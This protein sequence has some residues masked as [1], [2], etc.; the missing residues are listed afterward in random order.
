MGWTPS[1]LSTCYPRASR[2]LIASFVRDIRKFSIVLVLSLYVTFGH[3]N[4]VK[5]TTNLFAQALAHLRL[6]G[7]LTLITMT[8]GRLGELFMLLRYPEQLQGTSREFNAQLETASYRKMKD[9]RVLLIQYL[10]QQNSSITGED[11]IRKGASECK[12]Y[13]GMP[14]LTDLAVM[15][16]I[17]PLT[18]GFGLREFVTIVYGSLM[19]R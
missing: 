7:I 16:G 12:R 11:K 8:Y 3:E 5:G 4:F 6:D 1:F 9:W 13:C 19:C 18:F 14:L 15:M 10:L 2:I 17:D